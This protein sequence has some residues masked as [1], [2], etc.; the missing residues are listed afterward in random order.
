MAVDDQG[1][2][3][4]HHVSQGNFESLE[5]GC[6]IAELL[7]EGGVDPNAQDNNLET[8]LHV[9]SRWGRPEIVQVLLGHTTVKNARRP[10]SSLLGLEGIYSSEER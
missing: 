3:P 9:A 5:A 4:L 10:T 7:L 6:R 2:T 1:K 8:P